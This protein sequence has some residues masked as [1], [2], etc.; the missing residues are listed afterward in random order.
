MPNF[1]LKTKMSLVVSLLAAAGLSFVTL[2][3]SWYFEKQFKE[4]ISRQQFTMISALAEEIDSKVRTAQTELLFVANTIKPDI[5]NNPGSAQE[6]LDNRP[7]TAAMFDSGVFLFS[8]QGKLLAVTPWELLLIHKNYA[9][10]EYIEETVRTGK[11]HISEPFFS[12]QKD[13]PPTI[14]FTAPIFD[15]SGKLAGI[16]AG[17]LDLMKDNFLGKLAT[18]NI[19]TKGYLYLYNTDRTIIVHPDRTRILKKDVSVGTN[20][21]F[22]LAVKGFEGT[23]ETVN[24]RGMS[25]L[26]SFKRL[27]TTNWIL[28]ANYPQDEAYAPI[29]RV[30]W[31]LLAIFSF[32]L[33]L[34]ILITWIFMRH[35]TA[36]LL[37]FTRHVEQITGREDRLEPIPVKA[38]DEIG[39]L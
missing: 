14:M 19:G 21:L 38:R 1:S 16:L 23:G 26:S 31:H 17:S 12:T 33:F 32:M 37:L 5:L 29:Y 9:Y 27:K 8:P 25:L 4:T 20:K 10:R 22:D 13:R 18:V 11:P 28:A 7:D 35:L 2:S 36:P 6:F 30:K 34:S 3:A 39:T 15:A 24:S